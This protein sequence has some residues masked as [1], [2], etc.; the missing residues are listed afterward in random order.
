MKIE[1]KTT[2]TGEIYRLAVETIATTSMFHADVLLWN[3]FHSLVYVTQ[4]SWQKIITYN[5]N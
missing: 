2:S 3:W 5:T 4:T 1:M